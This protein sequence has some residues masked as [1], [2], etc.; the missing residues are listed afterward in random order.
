[1]QEIEENKQEVVEITPIKKGRRILLFLA[2]FFINFILCFVLFNAV[3]M[4]L[5]NLISNS[6]ARKNR[7]DDAARAQFDI[8]YD[9]KVMFY[10]KESEKYYYTKNVESTLNCYLS[11]YSFEDDDELNDHPLYGNKKENEVLY[12]FYKDIRQD[13]DD[14]LNLLNNFNKEHEFFV[15]NGENISLIPSVKDNIRLSFLSPSDISSGGEKELGYLQ[16]FFINAYAEVFKNIE[17]NDLVFNE[18]SYLEY[19]KVVDACEKELQVLLIVTSSISLFVS[20]VACYFIFPFFNKENKTLAMLIMKTVRIGTNNLYLLKKKE[21]ILQ[22]LYYLIFNLPILFFMPMTQ[23]AFSYLFNIV[24]LTS[25]LFIGILLWL[26]SLVV[27]LISPLG[28]S[29]IDFLS[30][31]T[32]IK[33]DDLDAIYRSKGYDI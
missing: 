31:S 3:I 21:L 10:E 14:Y 28:Q 26:I 13:Y 30:R 22:T 19:K 15:I 27:V 11:Y 24:P 18:K 29:L 16:D 8:L 23:V 7:N 9:S 32:L 17:D 1:M 33:N 5:G 6:T 25:L 4:P 20:S 12:H 2:D